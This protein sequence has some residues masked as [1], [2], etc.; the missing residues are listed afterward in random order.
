[1]HKNTYKTINRCDTFAWGWA[2]H[3]AS[4]LEVGK[5]MVNCSEH[6]L[7]VHLGRGRLPQSWGEGGRHNPMREVIPTAK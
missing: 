5:L 2:G 7:E 1:M 4:W 6:A 3:H